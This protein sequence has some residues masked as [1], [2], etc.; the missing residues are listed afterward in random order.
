M[1]TEG[2][3][4]WIELWMLFVVF[5]TPIFLVTGTLWFLTHW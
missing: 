5:G 2:K 1:T 4:D 3:W